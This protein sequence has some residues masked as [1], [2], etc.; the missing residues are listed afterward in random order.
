MNYRTLGFTASVLVLMAFFQGCDRGLGPITEDTGFSGTITY[1]N[2]PRAD[3]I[4]G[5]RLVALEDIPR[6]APG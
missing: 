1:K 5:L 6:T 4:Y 2:W 3:S